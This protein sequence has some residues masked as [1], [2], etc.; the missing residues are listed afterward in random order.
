M[1]CHFLLQG[2]FLIQ[3]FNPSLLHCRQILYCLSHQGSSL[4][5]TLVLNSKEPSCQCRTCK[6]QG[7]YPCVGKIPWK[8]AYNW[9]DLACMQ[10]LTKH[11]Y[12]LPPHLKGDATGWRLHLWSHL[13]S[14]QGSCMLHYN[15]FIITWSDI[16]FWFPLETINSLR[17]RTLSC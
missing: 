12:R 3:E 1:G 16:P 5:F 15:R 8:R 4:F 17:I 9:S 7:F 10:Y 6:K 2:I 11:I 14:C 13:W